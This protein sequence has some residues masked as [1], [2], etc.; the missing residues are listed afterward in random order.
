M[1]KEINV[2]TLCLFCVGL[3]SGGCSHPSEHAPV[4]QS[5]EQKTAATM[6]T[7]EV[8]VSPTPSSSYHMSKEV[9]DLLKPFSGWEKQNERIAIAYS[10]KY[11]LEAEA[12]TNGFLVSIGCVNKNELSNGDISQVKV[13]YDLDGK[14][15]GINFYKM[16]IFMSP[17]GKET[18]RIDVLL[19][20]NFL[21]PIG[22]DLS[23]TREYHEAIA[24]L[25][26]ADVFSG[27]FITDKTVKPRRF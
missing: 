11:L 8:A 23:A 27:F 3:L 7:P 1:S 22:Q 25:E 24:E 14:V 2:R 9:K 21:V 12:Y 17:E 20:D 13:F 6:P 18:S 19:N 26:K 5:Y 4:G 10:G 15:S 16:R